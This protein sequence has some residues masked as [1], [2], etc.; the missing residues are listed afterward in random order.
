LDLDL[1]EYYCS[2]NL[3]RLYRKRNRKGD[4]ERAQAVLNIVM[5]ACD[6]AKRRGTSDEWLRPTLLA[7]AFDL[8]DAN[9]AEELCDEVAEEGPALWQIDSIVHDLE[10]SVAQVEDEDR[11]KRLDGVI[12]RLKAY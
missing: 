7:G 11:R 6:R 10:R 5:A 2:S 8:G 4:R 12:T 9:K 3:P 1:N